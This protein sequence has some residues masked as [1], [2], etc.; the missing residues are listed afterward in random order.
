[1]ILNQTELPEEVIFSDD[2]SGDDTASIIEENRTRFEKLGIGLNI[3][4]N[5][6]QGPGAA[7]NHGVF[8]ASQPW[9]AFLDADDVWK[10]EKIFYIRQ[11]M[12]EKPNSNCFLHWEEYIKMNGKRSP[13][14]HG[15]NYYNSD[16][17]LLP[18]LYR[19]NFLST[20]TIVCKKQL[21]ENSGGF[22]TTLP[23]AQDYELWLRMSSQM[24][25]TIIPKILGEY[26]EQSTS[27]TARPYY[28]RFWSEMRIAMRYRKKVNLNYFL[29]K[30]TKIILSKQ[31]FYTLFNLLIREKKH[32]N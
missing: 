9:I 2:G 32:S 8:K 26:I 22:D 13:L 20:S 14:K 1:S 16:L 18:Q 7:R 23:N 10:N 3:D 21:I 5:V 29:Y 6:H 11:S 28:I 25:L 12:Q 30:I 24:N 15:F 17:F 19:K 31:W 27:I 4:C